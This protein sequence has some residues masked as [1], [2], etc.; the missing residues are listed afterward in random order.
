MILIWGWRVR[1]KTL[2]QGVFFCPTC[3]GDR[4]YSRQQGRRWFTLFFLPVIPLGHVGE[5]FVHCD[6]CR[7]DYKLRALDNPTTAALGEHLMAATREAVVWLLRTATPGAA[8]VAAALDVLSASAGR[9]WTEPELQADVANLDVGGL[10]ARLATLAGSLT[11]QGKESFLAGCTRVAVADGA[12]GDEARRTL[13]HV[14]AS[15][16][17]TPAHARGVIAQTVEQAGL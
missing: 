3:G 16:G 4:Q 2:A 15:L 6:T 1:F 12:I 10:S 9:P 5:E 11:T 17:M 7:Q 8:A 14:A 13:D